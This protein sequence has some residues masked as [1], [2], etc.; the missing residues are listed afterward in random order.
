MGIEPTLRAWEAPVLPLNYTRTEL[1]SSPECE[2][3]RYSD[4]LLTAAASRHHLAMTQERNILVNGEPRRWRDSLH[5]QDLVEELGLGGKRV[6]VEVN[7]QIVP[8]S[9]HAKHML[10]AG[11]QVEIVQAIG[12]G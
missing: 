12:G 11:D 8:R 9:Q 5:L 6:A 7:G 2:R 3:I 1:H 4:A 10:Q